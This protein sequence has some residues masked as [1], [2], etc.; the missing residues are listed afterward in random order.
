ML[1]YHNHGLGDQQE[2]MVANKEQ[3]QK[4]VGKLIYLYHTRLD[5]V[6]TVNLMSQLMHNPNKS[7]MDTVYIGFWDI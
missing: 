3:Y 2:Y 6:Y 5:I 1:E 4:L 7:H